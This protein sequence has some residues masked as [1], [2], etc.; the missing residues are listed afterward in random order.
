MKTDW[1]VILPLALVV[2]VLVLYFVRVKPIEGLKDGRVAL[3]K[4]VRLPV[5][6]FESRFA[7]RAYWPL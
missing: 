5:P 1:K 2:C 4:P 6:G 7:D 3:G